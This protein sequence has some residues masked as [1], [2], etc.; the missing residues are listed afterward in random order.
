ME[1]VHKIIVVQMIS[2]YDFKVKFCSLCFSSM[3]LLLITGNA[4]HRSFIVILT[5]RTYSAISRPIFT[6]ILT[7]SGTI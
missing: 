1:A 4:L 7:K 2:K 3:L 6:Q 5:Y